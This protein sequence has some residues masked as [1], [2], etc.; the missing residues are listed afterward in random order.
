VLLRL[1]ALPCACAGRGARHP[2]LQPPP[3]PPGAA[4]GGTKGVANAHMQA[5]LRAAMAN[6]VLH[7]APGDHKGMLFWQRATF[8]PWAVAHA[9]TVPPE[10]LGMSTAEQHWAPPEE[11]FA[12][13]NMTARIVQIFSLMDANH[14]AA[15][16]L[17]ELERWHHVNKVFIEKQRAAESLV[18]AA[19]PRATA[20]RRASHFRWSGPLPR[21][22]PRLRLLM[23]RWMP[24]VPHAGMQC[25]SSCSELVCVLRCRSTMTR[26]ETAS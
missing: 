26:T 4:S 10:L 23:Q 15:I 7:R 13:H 9:G 19:P 22:Q 11:W 21:A 2:T 14:D 16:E 18:R 25:D 20:A 12:T 6:H 5:R 24:S 8:D 1:A 17:A 3:P